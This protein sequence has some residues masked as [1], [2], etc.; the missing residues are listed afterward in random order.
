MLGKRKRDYQNIESLIS[1]GVEVKGEIY[2][3]GSIRIDGKVE[4][5]LQLKGDLIIGEG[6]QVKG[7]LIVENL[8]LAGNLQGNATARER[9]EI[10]STG[11]MTGDAICTV[12]TIE[13]GGALEGRSQM[14][15]KKE[16]NDK[17]K[18]IN[19]KEIE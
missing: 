4:G 17:E 12:L 11:V 5:K 7:D 19:L 16:K 13:E 18:R 1:E 14:S 2:S 8:I 3:K 10:T 6:A 15:R 9:L